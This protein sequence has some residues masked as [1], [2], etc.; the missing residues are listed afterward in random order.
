MKKFIRIILAIVFV[1]GMN[2]IVL[3]E[4]D[5]ATLEIE[6]KS[7]KV[8]EAVRDKNPGIKYNFR[9]AEETETDLIKKAGLKCPEGTN[10][11]LGGCYTIPK[12]N[13]GKRMII[14]ARRFLMKQRGL[15]WKEGELESKGALEIA[16]VLRAK[17]LNIDHFPEISGVRIGDR[18]FVI[19]FYRLDEI[20]VKRLEKAFEVLLK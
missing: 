15:I 20:P 16:E 1:M 6:S 19:F 13:Q 14:E 3:A 4:E 18:W 5:L 17:L 11:M 2:S 12:D 8:E 10:W 9:S 7:A